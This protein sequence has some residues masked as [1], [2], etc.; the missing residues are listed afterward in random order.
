MKKYKLW[1]HIEEI[2]EEENHYVDL[3]EHTESLG[4]ELNTKEEALSLKER[5]IDCAKDDGELWFVSP[6]QWKK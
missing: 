4:P 5:L 6:K 2:D 3:E 1:L